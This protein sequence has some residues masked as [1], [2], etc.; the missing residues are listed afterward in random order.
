MKLVT[1]FPLGFAVGALLLAGMGGCSDDSQLSKAEEKKFQD[2]LE[3]GKGE[4]DINK[5][6]PEQQE[7]VRALMEANKAPS[8]TGSSK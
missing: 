4:F 1:R 5:V 7:R 3:S 6:P 2:S 8:A